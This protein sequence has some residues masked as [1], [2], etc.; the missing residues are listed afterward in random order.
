LR[1]AISRSF[2]SSVGGA[3]VSRADAAA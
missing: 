3:N 1:R 2:G